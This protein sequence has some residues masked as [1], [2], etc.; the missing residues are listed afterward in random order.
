MLRYTIL[1]T[2]SHVL[3]IHEHLN[4]NSVFQTDENGTQRQTFLTFVDND[5]I[6]ELRLLF[7]ALFRRRVTST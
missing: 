1:T 2:P 5:L 3:C 4:I 7:K 6:R